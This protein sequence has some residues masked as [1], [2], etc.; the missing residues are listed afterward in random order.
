MMNPIYAMEI[1][2]VNRKSNKKDSHKSSFH[3]SSNLIFHLLMFVG[4]LDNETKLFKFELDQT[5]SY[6]LN[7]T[8][9]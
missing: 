8:N 6:E 2:N 1:R 4:Y 5:R 9:F 3:V 7:E